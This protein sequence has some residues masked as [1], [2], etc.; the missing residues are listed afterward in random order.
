MK[1]YGK[2]HALSYALQDQKPEIFK[3][4]CNNTEE[5]FFSHMK[6]DEM[7]KGIQQQSEKALNAL[8]PVK[9]KVAYEKFKN[10]RSAMIDLLHE[11]VK[12]KPAGK[13]AV[14]GHGDC[15]VNNM[16]FKYGNSAKP[17]CPT[18]M[19][20]L[21][22]QLSRLGSP[23]LDL[24]YFIF[25]A[26][27]KNLRDQHYDHLIQ[28]YYDSLSSFLRKLGSDPDKILPFNVLQEHLKKFS[29]YGLYMAVMLLFIMTSEVEEIP[30]IHNISDSEDIMS[31]FQY[32]SKNME[33]YN[34]RIRG[35]I[36]DF[37]RLG[38]DF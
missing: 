32:D 23:A 15:W 5:T 11:A 28:E 31:K 1:E 26:T 16:L 36:L 8:D 35:V 3:E 18:E 29:V 9:H 30:D 14:I 10:F 34:E 4:L 17:Q 2:F 27:D 13:Y 19:C 12:A 7:H 6:N 21:D 33:K 24:S 38:Y 37:V 25:T 20:F 22:W